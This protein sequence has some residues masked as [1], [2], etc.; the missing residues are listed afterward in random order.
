MEDDGVGF[1]DAPPE[2]EA[3]AHIGLSLL[4][5]RA[6]QLGG[7]LRVESEP[8]EGVQVMLEFRAAGA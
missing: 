5:D 1:A 7:Q 4:H 8:G 3:G 6:R 2:G